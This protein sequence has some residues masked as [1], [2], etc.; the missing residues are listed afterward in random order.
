MYVPGARTMWPTPALASAL[1]RAT[2]L[3]TTVV[4]GGYG[5]G[6]GGDGGDG[7]EGGEGGEGRSA[8][9][10]RVQVE[11]EPET[12]VGVVGQKQTVAPHWAQA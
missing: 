7:G 6:D 1:V 4:P 2:V 3:L 9:G 12:P 11:T 10:G 8:G 5:G